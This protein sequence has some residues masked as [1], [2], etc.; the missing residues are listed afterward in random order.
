MSTIY[1]FVA[2]GKHVELLRID[3]SL[4]GRK[5]QLVTALSPDEASAVHS[6]LAY[7]I[8][9]A[10]RKERQAD[11]REL[12]RLR[13]SRASIERQI[14]DLEVRLASALEKETV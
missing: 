13:L 5:K 8:S 3:S 4:A 10:R 7:A 11:M 9:L 1:E 2:N 14:G 12:E 6:N